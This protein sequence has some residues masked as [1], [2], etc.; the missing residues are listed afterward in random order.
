MV[1]ILKWLSVIRFSS[2]ST[3]REYNDE[4]FID[5]ALERELGESYYSSYYNR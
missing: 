4:L 1:V 5:K 3:S 2:I